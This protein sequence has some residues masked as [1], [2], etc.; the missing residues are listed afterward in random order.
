[1]RSLI[2]IIK[3]SLMTLTYDTPSY[4]EGLSRED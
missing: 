3:I 4:S 2:Y 1:M